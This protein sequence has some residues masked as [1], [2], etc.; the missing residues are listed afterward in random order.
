MAA[1]EGVVVRRLE[2]HVDERGSLTE[3]LRSDWP[4]FTRF[5]QAIVTLN[6]PG[7]I[8][9]WHWHR[10]QTDVIVV[11]VGRVVV[12]LYDGRQGS[13]TFGEVQEHVLDASCPMTLFIPPGVYHGYRTISRDPAIIVNFP[14]QTYDP[15][16][17]DEERVPH[18]AQH[19]PY[20][21]DAHAG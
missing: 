17:P 18:D 13:A 1:I 19:I 14:D 15:L 9:G 16:S 6:H 7:V 3:V 20:D 12:P 8:R 21:W 2:P 10:R 4:E 11:L 5:G